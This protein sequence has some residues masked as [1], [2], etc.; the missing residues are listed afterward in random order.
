MV[1]T[2]SEGEARAVWAHHAVRGRPL[3]L[4]RTSKGCLPSRPR[5]GLALARQLPIIV[6]LPSSVG[7]VTEDLAMILRLRGWW[8]DRFVNARRQS[9]PR[10][11]L[12]QLERR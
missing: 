12:E 2:G 4:R 1:E 10:P 9:R 8:C 3:P 7:L 11:R 5:L 6:N